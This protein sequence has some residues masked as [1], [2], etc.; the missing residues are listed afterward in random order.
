MDK[1]IVVHPDSGILFSTE[2]KWA[3][4]PSKDMEKT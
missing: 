4:K 3:I 1:Y 2:N